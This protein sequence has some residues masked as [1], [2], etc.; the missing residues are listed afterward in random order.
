MILRPYQERLVSRAV[1]ALNQRGNTLAVSPTGS[2]KTI[3]LAAL[4][5]RLGGRQCVL[6]HRQELTEQNMSKFKKVNPAARVSLYNADVKSWSGDTT[7]AMVQTLARNGNL[8][9]IPALDLLI[10]DEAH[11]A[12]AES[13]RRIIDAALDKNPECKIAGFTATPA[14]GDGK[15]L[16]A[17][18]DNCCDQISL[19]SLI[20]LGFLVKPRTFVCALEGVDE[21][22]KHLRKMRGGEYDLAQAADVLDVDVHNAAVVRE[23]R[24]LA[25]ERRTIV[26][27]STVEHARHVCEAFTAEGVRAATVTGEMPDHE[28]AA[29]L[30]RFDKGNI[31]VLV[32]VAVLTEGYDSQPVS[33]IIL[34][35]PCSFKS[36]MLQMIGR[37]LRTVDPALY[38]G[39]VKTDCIVMDFGRSLLTHGDLESKVQFED[40]QKVCP[41]CGGEVPCGT[42]EC[43]ICGHEFTAPEAGEAG[44]GEGRETV[45]SVEMM[46][47]DILNASPFKWIDLFGTSKVMI[48]S[49]FECWCAVISPDGEH[50]SALGKLKE[51]R[52][53]HRLQLGE[54]I[55]CLA[56]ADDFL[57]LN[58]S[59]NAAKKN[60]A[61][62]NHPA[63]EKQLEYLYSFGYGP[64]TQLAFTK[65]S[66]AC[67]MNFFFARQEI[68]RLIFNNEYR[69]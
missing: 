52:F 17:V 15:G 37:G 3:M 58:E 59:D 38:P 49:G 36:T 39:V 30:T 64:E 10:I 48:A 53:V 22:L 50:W 25:G 19:N 42:M 65:Y 29:T 7:F 26:F 44:E 13:Y 56:A 33:C 55:P 45:S 21:E 47:V 46:E 1:A 35:R 23:W 57:R 68:E 6:Q 4:G 12:T 60:K 5:A 67:T 9:S 40:K 2:G 28:R 18:F 54:R 62:L 31:Q 41:E 24:K 66:A 16:R 51:E 34:L 69:T 43:P 11:H 20:A 61:W 32:N 8:N 14:R 63:T 27:C